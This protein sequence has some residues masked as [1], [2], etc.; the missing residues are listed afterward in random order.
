MIPSYMVSL[1]VYFFI[2]TSKQLSFLN[3]LENYKMARQVLK[4]RRF[5]QDTNHLEAA[6]I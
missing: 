1:L 3:D 5:V 2:K 4:H 6:G